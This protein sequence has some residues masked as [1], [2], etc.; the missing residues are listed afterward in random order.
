MKNNQQWRKKIMKLGLLLIVGVSMNAI[1]G[2]LDLGGDSWKEEVL[3]HDGQKIIVQRTQSYGGRSEFGQAGPIKKHSVSFTLPGSS[4]YIIWNSE[5]GEDL[6]RTNFNLMAVH[7]LNGTAYIVATPNLCLSYN[8]WGRPNPPYIFFRYD[9]S[10]WIR[11]ML[12]QFPL[13]FKTINVVLS[14]QKFQAEKLSSVPLTSAEKIRDLN[15]HIDRPEYK[16][17][18]REPVNYDP[19]CIPMVTN[20]KGSWRAK[21]WFSKKPTREAC[22][23]ACTSDDFDENTCPCKK[24]FEGM[25]NGGTT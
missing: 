25:R 12:E 7:V 21:A 9:G 13:E 17:I 2:W 10:A 11:I 24:I 5:F 14:I 18:L 23:A 20:G 8:K 1:A 3:L 15:N 4:Q 19:D 6:G 16:T 22:Q